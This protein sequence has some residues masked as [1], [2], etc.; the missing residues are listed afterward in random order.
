MTDSRYY[1][2]HNAELRRLL[3]NFHGIAADDEV[4]G[5]PLKAT[6]PVYRFTFGDGIPAMVGKFFFSFPPVMPPDRGLVKEYQ[7]YLQA[8]GF[9]MTGA[10]SRI[11]RLLG[12]RPH[13]LLGLLLED[14]PGPDLDF[15]L[16]E[17]ASPAGQQALCDK[18]EKLAELLAFFHL[19]PQPPECVSPDAALRYFHKLMKQLAAG[20]VL[21]EEE[22]RCFQAER[23]AWEKILPAFPDR[24]VLIHGDA[25]P[26]N[27]LFPDGRAVGLDLERLRVADRLFDLS[28]LAGEIKH[29]WGWRFHNFAGSEPA[30]GHFLQAYC[31]AINADAGLIDRILR[32]NPF[33]MALA[34]LRIARNDYLSWE[35]RRALIQEAVCCLTHGRRMP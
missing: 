26:T 1:P 5:Q 21:T 24:R 2:A 34:E 25:T 3:Q 31:G 13:M 14:I 32:L 22:E 15:F 6:R 23:A 12:C 17:A 28:W 18:L 33:Y 9:G 29:A 7:A 19:R 35:Y 30:I 11:P 27:F 16:M 4:A 8:P 10:C 20:G